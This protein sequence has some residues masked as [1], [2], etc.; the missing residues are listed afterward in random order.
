VF[1]SGDPGDASIGA[2]LGINEEDSAN[3]CGFFENT[4][5]Y[6]EK[7]IGDV[8]VDDVLNVLY[9]LRDTGSVW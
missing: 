8:G 7:P 9:R 4:A 6:R 2:W 3:L 5:V 1:G